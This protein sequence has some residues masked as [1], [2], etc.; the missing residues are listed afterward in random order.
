MYT[1]YT[2]TE[3]IKRRLLILTLCDSKILDTAYVRNKNST[4]EYEKSE[5]FSARY[6]CK[7]R[8]PDVT[9]FENVGNFHPRKNKVYLFYI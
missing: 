9:R 1:P 7:S 4:F 3:N 6:Q 2:Q 8:P 5:Y